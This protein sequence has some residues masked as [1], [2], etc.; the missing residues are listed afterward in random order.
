M[1]DSVLGQQGSV[2]THKVY[3]LSYPALYRE[4]LDPY[5]ASEVLLAK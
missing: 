4:S 3:N 2:G 5:T 1:S